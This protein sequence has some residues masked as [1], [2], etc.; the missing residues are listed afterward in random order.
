VALRTSVTFRITWDLL[1][2][3]LPTRNPSSGQKANQSPQSTE[4]LDDGG[5]FVFGTN[6]LQNVGVRKRSQVELDS[7]RSGIVLRVIA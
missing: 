7:K 1:S 2:G 5:L 4:S 3:T 6:L